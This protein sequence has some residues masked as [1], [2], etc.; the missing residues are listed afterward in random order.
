MVARQ[1]PALAS[2]DFQE[3]LLQPFNVPRVDL[4]A[5]VEDDCSFHLALLVHFLDLLSQLRLI[6][7][8]ADDTGI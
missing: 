4:I 8:A 2:I 6:W 5:E 7:V 1:L 3:C